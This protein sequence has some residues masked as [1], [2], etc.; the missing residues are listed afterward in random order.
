[1]LLDV[2]LCLRG[3]PFIDHSLSLP[4]RVPLLCRHGRAF[5]TVRLTTVALRRG[6]LLAVACS[7]LLGKTAEH[8]QPNPSIG[9][10]VPPHT[11][12]AAVGVAF[13]CILLEKA[14]IPG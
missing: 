14:A 10:N 9:G 11:H 7:G 3:V 13:R 5:R 8:D 6:P 4:Q 12:V 1:V 2:G